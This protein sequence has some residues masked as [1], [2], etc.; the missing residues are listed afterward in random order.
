MKRLKIKDQ[1][2]KIRRGFISER[3]RGDI[4]TRK[5][6]GF[7]S[8][9]SEETTS[10]STAKGFTL[11]ELLIVITIIGV[12][13]VAVLS[14]INPVE[15]IRRAQDSG[16][17]S[18][19]AE[20]LN[21]FDRYY[22]AFF[23]FPWTALSQVNPSQAQVSANLAWIDELIAKGEVK[24]QFRDR[25]TWTDV[26]VTQS[27]TIVSVCFLPTSSTFQQQANQ[28]GKNLNGTSGCTTGCAVCLP[29]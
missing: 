24:T 23:K 16:R 14:A 13:A 17:E 22:T 20:L 11:I 4:T 19:S 9:R 12:L 18:D 26:Y 6:R 2:S 15:Q 3:I 8:E 1:I 29:R 21:S 27:G 5:T 25:A 7:I 28:R 10:L